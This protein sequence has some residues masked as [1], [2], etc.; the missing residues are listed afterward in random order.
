L[1]DHGYDLGSNDAEREQ[2][3]RDATTTYRGVRVLRG[4][5]KA[6]CVRLSD[7]REVWVPSSVVHDDSPAW[8]VGD[9]GNLIVKEWWAAK[10]TV[11]RAVRV[12]KLREG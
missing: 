5:A 3:M 9:E 4:S 2:L 1:R 12:W 6:I 7:G 8:R 10:Q 11:E